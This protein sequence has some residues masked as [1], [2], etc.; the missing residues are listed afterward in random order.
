MFYC[1]HFHSSKNPQTMSKRSMQERNKGE[2]FVL[3]KSNPVSLVSF[4]VSVNQSSMMDSGISKK[5]REFLNAQL[6]FRSNKHRTQNKHQV[7]QV[8]HRNANHR[9]MDASP[10]T[11]VAKVLV[12][13]WM[14][15]G[16]SWAKVAQSPICRLLV[17][18]TICQ[19]STGIEMGKMYRIGNVYLFTKNNDYSYRFT[20]P[21]TMVG[22][23]QNL[24]LVWKKLVKRVDLGEPTTFL[25]D[26]YL[27]CTQRERKLDK[28][29]IEEYRKLFDSR[30]SVGANEQLFGWEVSHAITVCWS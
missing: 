6:E 11:K 14:L 30:I 4:W 10:T 29:I 1:S 25:D 18:K 21:T 5:P 20:W 19:S 2:E 26:V 16:S 8:W 27:G 3:A 12:K 13:H 24:S 22:R 28:S 9:H 7:S 23:E 17:G 15:C